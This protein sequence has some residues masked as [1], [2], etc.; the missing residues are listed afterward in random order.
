MLA[1]KFVND[2]WNDKINIWWE[3]EK[4]QSAIAKFS[5]KY[6]RKSDKILHELEKIIKNYD[7]SI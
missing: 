3:S 1:S 5:E 6:A 2:I 7:S 4:T